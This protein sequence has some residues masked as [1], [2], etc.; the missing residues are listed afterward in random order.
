[1]H[2]IGILGL[3]RLAG[4]FTGLAVALFAVSNAHAQTGH[5]GF[6]A[7]ISAGAVHDVVVDGN[8]KIMVA[9]SFTFAGGTRR[10]A[11]LHPDGWGDGSFVSGINATAGVA[12]S[13][14]PV[15]SGYL[16]GG[17]FTGGTS[18]NYLAQLSATGANVAGLGVGV[19]GT[20]Y[21][22]NRRANGNG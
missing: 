12:H 22:V 18:P 17:S 21:T 19:N 5:D 13:I 1:M 4:L 6:A 8:G 14:L 7:A 10:V 11:R 15:G 9:G 16:V 3:A 2:H 20:V